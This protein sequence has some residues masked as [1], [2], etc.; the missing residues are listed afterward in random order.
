MSTDTCKIKPN[1]TKL[2]CKI[3]SMKENSYKAFA[4]LVSNLKF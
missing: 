3:Y 2:G 4:F 1:T